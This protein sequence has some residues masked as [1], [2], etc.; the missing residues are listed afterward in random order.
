M[1]EV[2]CPF[3]AISLVYGTSTRGMDLP[4]IST[5]YETNVPGLYIAGE[6]GGMGLIRNAVKQGKFAAEHAAKNLKKVKCDVDIT[7]IGAGPA[8]LSASLTARNKKV[9]Y[10]CLEQNSFGG[11]VYNFPRQKVVMS[12]PF[13]LPIVGEVK[14]PSHKV[15]KEDLLGV[16]NRI[17]QVAF[18]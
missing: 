11:T 6:L 4:R 5:D 9:N 14:F 12:Q 7:I 15:S 2:S 17:R 10:V 8:G 18:R 13:E 16:W 3:E 1:C